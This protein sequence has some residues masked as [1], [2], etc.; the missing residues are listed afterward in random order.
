M[1]PGI[2]RQGPSGTSRPGWNG[3]AGPVP[4]QASERDSTSSQAIQE[5]LQTPDDRTT[6]SKLAI[7]TAHARSSRYACLNPEI[8]EATLTAISAGVCSWIC[9]IFLL[10]LTIERQFTC[11]L[12][13][14][15][16]PAAARHHGSARRAPWPGQGLHLTAQDRADKLRATAARQPACTGT[17]KRTGQ[18]FPAPPR[19]RWHRR[20]T[21]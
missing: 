5:M 4:V 1:R 18:I 12:P 15:R 14:I 10:L 6:A 17:T 8:T 7:V 9:V 11:F 13:G 16:V 20:G 3:K 2:G 21:R 19:P